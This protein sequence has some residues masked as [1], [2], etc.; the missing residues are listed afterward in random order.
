MIEYFLAVKQKS[1][2]DRLFY[3]FLS[4]ISTLLSFYLC[5]QSQGLVA[6]VQL[7]SISTGVIVALSFIYGHS[8]IVGV[9]A[10]L[11]T[12]YMLFD[13]TPDG[14]GYLYSI[15]I[16]VLMLLSQSLFTRIYHQHYASRWIFAYFV[17]LVPGLCAFTV[18]LFS[19]NTYTPAQAFNLF[20]TDSIGIL[21][22]APVAGLIATHMHQKHQWQ[23]LIQQ[24]KRTSTSRHLFK[25][26]VITAIFFLL[27]YEIHGENGY[28]LYLFLLPLLIITAFNFS[29]LTQILLIIIGYSLFIID[30]QQL[31]LLTFNTRL[32][33]FFMFSLV[34]YIMLDFKY[35]L[36][37][38]T[39]RSNRALYFDH[40]SNFGTFQKLDHDTIQR[41]DFIV[42]AIDLSEIFKQPLNKRDQTLRKISKCIRDHTDYYS[43]SYMLYDVA[44]L[45][46]MIENNL[47]AIGR[48]EKL[49]PTINH[50]LKA[51]GIN[52]HIHHIFFCRCHKGNRIRQTINLL[53]MNIRLNDHRHP[54]PLVDCA[55][56]HYTPYINLLEQISTDDIHL[57]RQNYQSKQTDKAVSFELLSRFY[58]GGEPL[59]TEQLFYCAHRLGHMESLELAIL[60]KALRYLQDL[61]E[62]N[63][64]YGSINLSPDFLSTS[65]GIEHLLYSV[66]KL[67]L[68][69]HKVCVEVV[70]SGTIRNVE[71]L[72]HNLQRLRNAGFI[73]ALDDF[74][75]GHS[76]YNQLLNM[77][78]DTVK[79]DGSLVRDCYQ[80]AIKRAIIENLREV[81]KLANIK[82]VAECVETQAEQAWLQ[83]LGIDY[84]Q[85]YLIHK[86]EAV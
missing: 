25:F 78:I 85:G 13:P 59:N 20:L 5:S 55:N 2:K 29:E 64:E 68:L 7:I 39:Q 33:I 19:P 67:N 40:Q 4:Y 50:A 11:M 27:N 46:I 26:A 48:L 80:D 14:M 57:V 45:V 60:N 54:Q 42:A 82:I 73:I 35:S 43:D 17:F 9:F 6:Q 10:G 28:I 83:D 61:P 21:L 1:L 74:G 76:T 79:I 22:A 63:Y 70:E 15:T 84:L 34:V 16:T 47:R 77:P 37:K 3:G 86:P 62:N 53:H 31:D 56:S 52:F 51:D 65:T 8:G 36:R 32:T 38:E 66:D 71:V 41:N 49:A 44:S 24:F 18:G 75:A 72:S 30:N 81:T 12:H 69:P 23:A 58:H